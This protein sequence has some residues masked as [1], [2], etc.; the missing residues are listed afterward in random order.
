M[1]ALTAFIEYPHLEDY[2]LTAAELHSTI[3]QAKER[4]TELKARFM[5]EYEA[6]SWGASESEEMPCAVATNG[7]VTFRCYIA[8]VSEG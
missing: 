5:E 6:E 8:D 3:D 4:S 2:K 7:E 1:F